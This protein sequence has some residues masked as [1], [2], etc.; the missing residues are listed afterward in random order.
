MLN[1]FQH[2]KHQGID[3]YVYVEIL[4]RVQNDSFLR[5]SHLTFPLA[6]DANI[7][8]RHNTE[9]TMNADFM[10]I[11]NCGKYSGVIFTFPILIANIIMTIPMLNICPVSRIVPSVAEATP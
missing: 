2:L 5:C 4:K 7:P 8:K 10:L 6:S 3:N 11:M 9:K 1:L